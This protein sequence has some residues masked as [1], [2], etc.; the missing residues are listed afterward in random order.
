[1]ICPLVFV[2]QDFS[3]HLKYLNTAHDKY[4]LFKVLNSI[5]ASSSKTSYAFYLKNYCF[6]SF[7]VF[8]LGF[9]QFLNLMSI[10]LYSLNRDLF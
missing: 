1:M 3:I 9:L 5:K 4:Q 8:N 10:F 6:Y 7:T 2:G